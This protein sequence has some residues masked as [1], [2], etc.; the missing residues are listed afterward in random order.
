MT[1]QT[2]IKKLVSDVLDTADRRGYGL[3]E[4]NYY[5][6]IYGWEAVTDLI[7]DDTL[8]DYDIDNGDGLN[9]T[10]RKRLQT[11]KPEAYDL[12]REI[13]SEAQELAD[14]LQKLG[15]TRIN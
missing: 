8:L 2:A 12:W 6:E 4:C 7:D 10:E 15:I 5:F 1:K 11:E 9:R 14:T 13:V 3:G